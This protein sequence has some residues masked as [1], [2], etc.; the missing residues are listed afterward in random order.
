MVPTLHPYQAFS[1][2]FIVTHPKCGLFLDMGLG[3]AVDDDTIIPTPT[4]RKRIGDI[5]VGDKIFAMNGKST[6]VTEVFKHPNKT[7]FKITLDDGRTFICCD[8]HLIPLHKSGLDTVTPVPLKN[9][10]NDYKI[11]DTNGNVIGYKYAIP[12][13]EPVQYPKTETLFEA[14]TL[15]AALRY[16]HV[17]NNLFVLDAE[18]PQWIFQHFNMLKPNILQAVLKEFMKHIGTD[19]LVYKIPEWCI[20]ADAMYKGELLSAMAGLNI[21]DRD[22]V[23]GTK[24]LKF[25]LPNMDMAATMQQIVWS[26]GHRITVNW[27]P[28]KKIA[29]IEINFSRNEDSQTGL[30][31]V[32]IKQVSNRN[33]TCFTVADSTHTYLINDYLVT[34]NTLITLMALWKIA[35][36]GHI[37]VIAPKTIARATW[38]NEI[39]KWNIPVRTKSLVVKENG[40]EL[41]R[42]KRLELYEQMPEEPPT[43]YFIN[44]EKIVDLIKNLPVR[45]GVK[46]WPFHTIVVDELQSFKNYAS[47]R[48]KALIEVAPLCQRFIGLT[49]TPTPQGL[50]DLWP[51]IF[52]MDNGARLGKN[53]T[54]YRNRWFRSTMIVNN[55]PVNWVPLPGAEEEIYSLISDL[56][57]SIKNPNIK[58]PPVTFNDMHITLDEDEM[59][60][61]KG[62]AKESAMILDDGKTV[63]AKNAGQLRI[64][65]TQLAS[66][67]VYTE[68][69][70]SDSYVVI[71]EKKLDACEYIINN[72]SGSVLIAY[73]FQ[74]DK[75]MLQEKFPT[76]RIFDGT[77][78]M[79]QEWND[80]KI[81]IM[82]LNPASAGHGLNMQ[83]GGHTLIWYTTPTNLEFYLQCNARLARQDQPDPVV[84]HHLIVD[85]T[86]DQAN[87][88]LVNMKDA[89]EERL[90][91]AVQ[92]VVDF[93]LVG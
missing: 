87:L 77:P 34:H 45:N 13:T 56:V 78:E 72:S 91:E 68:K 5:I 32:D 85:G 59:K 66:G 21:D 15:G 52:F 49:G 7:A 6:T 53:I 30:K 3:K 10:L 38:Q 65:L 35:P 26:M 89:N 63:T 39:A 9:L 54:A 8:E 47:D 76:A 28:R 12:W 23:R 93:A 81:P 88:T 60:L 29:E 4:G 2:D 57:I 74:A 84:I 18:T 19:G 82:M 1:A 61:Y 83:Y 80:R 11:T 90:I 62:F 25:E 46:I 37:L 67:S 42:K 27:R 22:T 55:H 69:G 48:T 44:R 51:E 33:M 75:M 40:K 73:Q 92:A 79:L 24:K 64:K 43:M 20:E 86:V 71:H 16:G 31:I 41:P 17:E 50:M 36:P 70:N 14:K 58:L